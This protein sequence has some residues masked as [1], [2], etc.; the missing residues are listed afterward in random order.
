MWYKPNYCTSEFT[1][2]FCVL[3]GYKIHHTEAEHVQVIVLKPC[4][5]YVQSLKV[6]M[7]VPTRY[8]VATLVEL[9]RSAAVEKINYKTFLK[10]KGIVE[11]SSFEYKVRE[12]WDT[13]YQISPDISLRKYMTNK[14]R[15]I[16][17]NKVFSLD[18]SGYGIL[19]K[20]NI[21]ER[22]DSS[23]RAISAAVEEA[24]EAA[25]LGNSLMEWMSK[26]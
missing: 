24:A 13:E 26:R 17:A 3:C 21:F 9:K 7:L 16:I 25:E 23:V 19:K 11:Y 22:A 5:N 18:I 20:Y 10:A 15:Q 14:E 4:N 12:F 2:R 8:G 1:A 6:G